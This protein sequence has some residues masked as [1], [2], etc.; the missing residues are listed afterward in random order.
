MIL[1]N[2][3]EFVKQR[4]RGYHPDFPV[5]RPLDT[6][7]VEILAD[8]AF[9]HSC[10]EVDGL[11]LLDTPRLANLWMLC[12]Q[13]NPAGH[14]LEVGSYKGGGALHLSNACPQRKTVV[15]DSFHGFETLDPQLD[16]SFT[17]DQFKDTSPQAV[18]ALF[19]SRKR[20]FAVIPGFFPQSCA[21]I[22]LGPISFVHLDVDTYKST[23][24]AL[25]FLAGRMIARSL[26]VLDDYNRRAHGV[27]EAVREF[28]THDRSWLAL[29]LFPGQGLL[30]HQSWFTT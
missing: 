1:K 5:L 21:N 11:T 14:I 8:E 19:R 9:Q 18:E 29:P 24:E 17:A 28:T 7:G 22:D 26:I 23:R 25:Q 27:D 3:L 4:L 12:Q 30:I 16:T 20:E 13:T 15:C 6:N 2:G 10:R